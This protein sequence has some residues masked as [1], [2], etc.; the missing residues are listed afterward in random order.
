LKGSV[1]RSASVP[2]AFNGVRR[3]R[4]DR[5]KGKPVKLQQIVKWLSNGRKE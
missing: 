5:G 1:H 3:C 4:E 2:D